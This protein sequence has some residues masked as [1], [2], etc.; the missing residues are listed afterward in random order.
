[1][2]LSCQT[3]AS[4]GRGKKNFLALHDH[5]TLKYF[6]HTYFAIHLKKYVVFTY[7]YALHIFPFPEPL[8]ICKYS[9]FYSPSVY[10][11]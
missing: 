5:N 8:N 9:V 2:R 10:V 7:F 1:M 4:T 11:G 6:S 3:I